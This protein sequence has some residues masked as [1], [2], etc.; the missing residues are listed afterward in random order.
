MKS[1]KNVSAGYAHSAFV[2]DAA[3]VLICGNGPALTVGGDIDYFRHDRS[4][5]FGELFARMTTPFHEAFRVLSRIDA[6]IVT[7][8]HGAV[9][10]GG[11]GEG[12]GFTFGSPGSLGGPCR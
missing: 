1:V 8:A 2:T 5:Q 9:A 3:E 4:E 12:G 6:P 7:A 10:G 11:L